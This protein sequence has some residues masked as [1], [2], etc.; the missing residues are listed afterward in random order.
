MPGMPS[1]PSAVETGA[2]GDRAA[3]AAAVREARG[4]ASRRGRARCRP[5]RSCGLSRRHL[6]HGAALHHLVDGF[7]L[8]VGRPLVHAST[9]V[10]IERQPERAHEHLSGAG[11]RLGKFLNAEILRGGFALRA[12]R[13]HDAAGGVS[14]G[15]LSLPDCARVRGSPYSFPAPAGQRGP[16]TATASHIGIMSTAPRRRPRCRLG[17]L[18]QPRRTTRPGTFTQGSVVRSL[19]SISRPRATRHATSETIP[20]ASTWLRRD[21]R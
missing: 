12:R 3:Q 5:R 4:S 7:R 2:I 13:E 8:G 10:R 6:A 18:L 20:A 9:H 19:L 15:L 11:Q 14:H 1:T 16:R 21:C 17:R